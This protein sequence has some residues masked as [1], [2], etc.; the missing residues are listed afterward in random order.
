VSGG[1]RAKPAAPQCRLCARLR[2][3]GKKSSRRP[4]PL[5]A[6]HGFHVA[7]VDGDQ[8]LRLAVWKMVRA[9]GDGW[10]LEVCHQAC[11]PGQPPGSSPPSPRT[12]PGADHD[13]GRPPDIVLVH[14]TTAHS[15]CLGCVRKL[16]SLAPD[17]PVVIITGLCDG[18]S[19]IQWL[20]AG[21]DGCLVG[22]VAAADLAS[23]LKAA[24]QGW[25]ALCPQAQK[26]VI[27]F[28]H[29]AGA[30]LLAHDLTGRE[31]DIAGCLMGKLS[32][33][34]MSERLRLAPN[35]VHVLT[36]HVF[37]KFGV[38]TR[39]ELLRKLLGRG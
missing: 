35:T 9:Q 17:L 28:L 36:A 32:R 27:D 23:V 29:R 3:W 20:M 22:P 19:I 8:G 31:Q 38:H 7:F 25:P 2:V 37:K 33:K 16:K 10:T 39:E 12:A 15:S 5:S 18:G 1:Q 26:A 21:A 14:L 11:F 4:P 34:E 13:A 24:A 30:S 6:R